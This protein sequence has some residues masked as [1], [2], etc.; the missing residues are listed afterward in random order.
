MKTG[1]AVVL[2]LLSVAP[3][4]GGD[5]VVEA[6]VWIGTGATWPQAF[7]WVGQRH[8][9]SELEIEND[10]DQPPTAQL[11]A[12]RKRLAGLSRVLGKEIRVTWVIQKE[13]ARMD[14]YGLVFLHRLELGEQSWLA[15]Y[16][17]KKKRG[18]KIGT[19]YLNRT[20]SKVKYKINMDSTQNSTPKRDILGIECQN[21]PCSGAFKGQVWVGEPDGKPMPAIREFMETSRVRFNGYA[22]ELLYHVVHETGG[23][24]FLARVSGLRGP[25]M[26]TGNSR[27][28][29][30]IMSVWKCEEPDEIKKGYFDLPQGYKIRKI[31]IK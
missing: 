23:M 12:A 14:M 24:P 7:A 31:G 2:I 3:L 15:Q 6:S 11:R 28:A 17:P 9:V 21:Y 25:N 19:E 10:P 4:C 30:T 18:V 27:P 16:S 5:A 22:G 29:M 1:I 13:R 20:W 8:R 26:T